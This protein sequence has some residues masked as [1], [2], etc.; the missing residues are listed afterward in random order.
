MANEIHTGGC[1]CGAVRFRIERGL[2]RSSICHCR[3]CQK[4]FGGFFGPLVTAK[5]LVWTHGEPARFRSSNKVQRGF[6]AKCGTPLTFEID[7]ASDI[8]V[9]IG[10]LDKPEAAEPTIEVGTESK[11]NFFGRLIGLPTRTPEEVAKVAAH[12]SGI[13]SFQHPDHDLPG[14]SEPSP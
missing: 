3:M 10:A 2:G 7:G 8:D 5:G 9:A 6:C 13:V 1:Q 12:Y 14:E 4:A 11:L